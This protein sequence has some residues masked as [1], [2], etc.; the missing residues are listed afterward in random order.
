M[1]K[2]AIMG[3]DLVGSILME[4]GTVPTAL[5]PLL[6]LLLLLQ[7]DSH[8]DHFTLLKSIIP[9]YWIGLCRIGVDLRCATF[10]VFIVVNSDVDVHDKL[11][12][13]ICYQAV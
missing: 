4:A 9:C 5:L 8:E 7:T 6:L 1:H 10:C 2:E 12:S 11:V 13:Y 3:L